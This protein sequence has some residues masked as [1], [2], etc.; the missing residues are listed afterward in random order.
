MIRFVVRNIINSIQKPPTVDIVTEQPEKIA[1]LEI[2]NKRYTSEIDKETSVYDF[3]TKLQNE[4]R[5]NFKDKNYIGMGKLI[6]ELNGIRGD[7]DRF[8][9]YYVNGKQAKIGVSNYKINPGDVVSWKYEKDY[10]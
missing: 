7:G 4:G 9:I 10:Q 1:T 8:W 3:M 6:E 5:V 2:E